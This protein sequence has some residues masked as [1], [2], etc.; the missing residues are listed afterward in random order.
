MENTGT[1]GPDRLDSWKAIATYLK[2]DERTVRRWEREQGLPVRR[3][4]G[5]RGTSVFAY[6][7]EIEAWLTANAPGNGTASEPAQAEP[8]RLPDLLVLPPH[9]WGVTGYAAAAFAI[10][11]AAIVGGRALYLASTEAELTATLTAEAIIGRDAGG[12]ERWRY[13]FTGARVEAPQERQRHPVETMAGEGPAFLAA[14]GLQVSVARETVSSGQLVS[15][16]RRGVPERTFSF[17]D[18]LTFGADTYDGP[19]GIT[20][21]R[22]VP[23]SGPRRIAVA[24]HHFQWSPSMIT[25]LDAQWRR[26]GTFVNAGW[27]ERIHWLSPDILLAGGFFEPLDGG[28]VTLLDANA[29]DGQSPVS[30]DSRF[31]CANCGKGRPLRYIVMQRS[32]V[33]RVSGSRFN[34]ARLEIHPDRIVARTQEAVVTETD[35]AEAMYEYTPSLEL[36]RASFSER[37]WQLHQSL[38]AQGKLTHT[39]AQCPDRDGP[40]SVAMWEPRTGWRTVQVR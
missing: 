5:G 38:E 4:P 12:R 32:E 18:R 17:D 37:Y 13:T 2:R 40:R 25:V 29:L 9:R 34:R 33:N 6:V 3:V 22:V 39:R 27:L 20:D 1:G 26:L 28:A 7:S 23:A 35:V 30:T 16:S 15:L 11:I 21:F 24:A 31:F 14:T 10:A 8:D 36:A 19:W